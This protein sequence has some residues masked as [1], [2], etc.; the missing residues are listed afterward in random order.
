VIITGA[1]HGIGAAT[2]Q[3]IAGP[4]TA[5]VL[6]DLNLAGLDGV[7]QECRAAGATVVTEYFDQAKPDTI[8]DLFASVDR[9]V[10]H[11]DALA[12][13]VGIYPNEP[14][15]TMSDDFWDH[16]IA[17]NLTGLFQC[18]RAGV[19][20]MLADGGGCVVNITTPK[21]YVPGRGFAAYAASKGGVEAFSRALALEGAPQVRV[22]VVCPGGPVEATGANVLDDERR[23]AAGIEYAPLA[24]WC[25]AEDVAAAVRFL[26]SE[27][28][29]FITG[30]VVR[31]DGGRNMA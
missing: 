6:A 26:L 20:R 12:N 15:E 28:A 8:E 11:I 17:T 14:I 18:C 3:A 1:A 2:A 9:Q 27:Q 22:N 31:V 10:G 5:M 21:V 24:R 30:Q 29:S 19:S 23:R 25:R 7:A 4:D 16:V 13:I